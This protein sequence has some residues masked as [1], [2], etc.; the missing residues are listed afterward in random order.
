[1]KGPQMDSE[2]AADIKHTKIVM[3]H[4]PWAARLLMFVLG[5][6]VCGFLCLV[7]L[8]RGCSFSVGPA[9]PEARLV[10]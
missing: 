3:G 6:A 5:L 2:T 10:P 8:T 9:H 7:M 4:V 1:M